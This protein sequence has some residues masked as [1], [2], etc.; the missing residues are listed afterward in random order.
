MFSGMDSWI[1]QPGYPLVTATVEGDQLVLD[2]RRFSFDTSS[3]IAQ[4]WLVPVHV[5]IE[6]VTS[7]HLLTDDVLRIPLSRPEATIIVNA[8]GHGFYR[9]DSA[10]SRATGGTGLGLAIVKH[11]CL[12]HGGECRV[13]SEVGVGS[14]FTLRLPSQQD[15]A[16]Q[17]DADG[18]GLSGGMS[19]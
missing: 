10:R 12:N 8:E 19:A 1:W 15:A 16:D 11:V 13:W 14:T 17:V 7:K 9:V 18:A 5:R 3:D 4:S 6:G 2:Q